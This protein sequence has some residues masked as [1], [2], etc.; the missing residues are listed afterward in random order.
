VPE[1]LEQPVKHTYPCYGVWLYKESSPSIKHLKK[2]L[3]PSVHGDRHWNSSYLL[4]DYF[5]HHPLKKNTRV[6]DVG[7]GW[8]PTAIYLASKG[9]RVTGLDVDQEVFAFL[10]VQANLNQVRVKT[11]QGAMAS[12]RKADLAEFDTIVGGDICFWDELGEEWFAMLKRAASA[13]VK[14]LLLADPGR[15]PFF[16][17]A[18]RCGKRWP[19]EIKEWYATEPR[20]FDGYLLVVTLNP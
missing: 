13:G 1:L 7:C 18:T 15:S 2:H 11:R 20:R 10:E 3:S 8:G 19:V 5:L 9:A 4:M 16:D 17:L 6:L 12:M 14:R